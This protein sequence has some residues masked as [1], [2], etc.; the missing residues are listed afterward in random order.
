MKTHHLFWGILFLLLGTLIFLDNVTI[1]NLDWDFI[2]NLWPVILVIIGL[3]ILI[4][5]T[6]YKWILVV[7]SSIIIGLVIFAIYKNIVDFF[8]TEI[9]FNSDTTTQS[10]SEPFASSIKNASLFVDV[11]AGGIYLQGTTDDLINVFTKGSAGNFN[12]QPD[13]TDD[14]A[15]LYL[16]QDEDVHFGKGLRKNRIEIKLNTNPVWDM[17]YD[18]GASKLD[19]DLS[20]YN[21]EDV[22][23]KS[24]VSSIKVKVGS[25]SDSTKIRFDSGVSKLH[26]L[27]PK[28]TGCVIDSRTELTNKHF[29]GFEKIDNDTYQTKNYDSAVKKVYMDLKADVSTINVERY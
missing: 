16:E 5:E 27:I 23:F 2:F 1:L 14:K 18:V 25:K 7:L 8:D 17:E 3:S 13:V 11:S 6:K 24:G 10:F 15:D 19:L 26:I 20:P 4:R 28:E 12:F 22:Y 29:S 21:T 9:E